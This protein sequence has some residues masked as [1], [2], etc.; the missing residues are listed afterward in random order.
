MSRL[1]V[2]KFHQYELGNYDFVRLLTRS[3]LAWEY[4]RRNQN[5]H[6]DWLHWA[7]GRPIPIALCDGT[8]LFR[9][10]RRHLH[11]ETWGLCMFR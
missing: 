3:R 10:R 9:L 6:S 4:L 5:Y 7:P 1:E 11:A 8:E 2:K